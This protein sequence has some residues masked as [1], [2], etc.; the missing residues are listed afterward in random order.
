VHLSTDYVF[1]GDL[2]RPY[3]ED[4]LTG[5]V[6]AYGR[7]K[8]AGEVEV[9]AA[10]PNHVILRT[11]WVYSPFGANF[12][13]TM[14]RLAQTRDV[15]GVVADQ[16][17]SPTSALDIA[18][19]ILRVCLNLQE[20]DDAGLYG[21]FHMAGSGYTTWADFAEAIFTMSR[22]HGG[23]SARVE[24]ISTSAYPTPAKRPGNSRLDCE[25]LRAVHGITMP[26]WQH[27]VAAC[28]ARLIAAAD[29]EQGQ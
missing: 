23:P 1:S 6:G 11:A 17:G 20:R 21:V 7:S 27:S 28:V 2:D 19:G 16:H 5:P 22:G 29:K 12:V 24:P 9:A 13:R 10:T 4:D 18:D 8:L 26:E 15:V 14:L 25:K 3:R